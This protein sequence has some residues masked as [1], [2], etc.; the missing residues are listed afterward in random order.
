MKKPGN[1]ALPPRQ[2]AEYPQGDQYEEEAEELTRGYEE[3]FRRNAFT[4]RP[5]Y[6]D[7]SGETDAEARAQYVSELA[8]LLRRGAGASPIKEA[9]SQM[10]TGSKPSDDYEYMRNPEAW[11]QSRKKI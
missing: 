10:S 5:D 3:S 1:S 9:R 4:P 8:E 7:I 11:N 6:I 2:G